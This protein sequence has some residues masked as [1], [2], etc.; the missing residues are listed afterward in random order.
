MST[1]AEDPV[2]KR[3]L[4]LTISQLS[5]VAGAE[6]YSLCQAIT[7][8]GALSDTEISELSRWID[9]N[10]HL[11]IPAIEHLVDTIG[12]VLADGHIDDSERKHLLK[13]IQRVLPPLERDGAEQR[14]LSREDQELRGKANLIRSFKGQEVHNRPLLKLDFMV[15]GVQYEG[16]NLIVEEQVDVDMPVFFSREVDNEYSKHA[17]AIVLEN[18]AMIGYLP[19]EYAPR[20]AQLLDG[21]CKYTARVKKVLEGRNVSI[22]VVL[23]EVFS[24]SATKGDIALQRRSTSPTRASEVSPLKKSRQRSARTKESSK[25]QHVAGR[26]RV[27]FSKPIVIGIFLLS[28]WFLLS[29]LWK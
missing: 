1:A 5:T 23:A 13:A 27:F 6:L 16:R 14:R 29:Q 24:R 2:K 28:L 19:E 18:N 12:K 15:A 25:P 7:H 9:D 10:R 11:E 4:S 8:D 3:R 17:I 20:V 26:G 21:G 22:P